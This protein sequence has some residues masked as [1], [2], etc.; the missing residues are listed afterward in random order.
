MLILAGK[1]RSNIILEEADFPHPVADILSHS[2]M[3]VLGLLLGNI[4]I[5]LLIYISIMP[6]HGTNFGPKSY[7]TL[8]H[9]SSVILSLLQKSSSKAFFHP[10]FR[11]CSSKAWCFHQ[12]L[13]RNTQQHVCYYY[14]NKWLDLYGRVAQ[15]SCYSVYQ[16]VKTNKKPLT[17]VIANQGYKVTSLSNRP[18]NL[19][20]NP[21]IFFKTS[22]CYVLSL[23]NEVT[24]FKNDRPPS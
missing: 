23:T 22:I 1:Y 11:P 3:H 7:N 19:Q 20:K 10:C 15:N 14:C 2:F 9:S 4:D 8:P 24:N 18:L 12:V 6:T 16:L 13:L 21:N 5:Q 17:T